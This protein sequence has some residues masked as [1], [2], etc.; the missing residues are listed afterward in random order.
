VGA[1]IGRE[2]SYELLAAVASLPEGELRGALAQLS[3]SELVFCR[4]TPPEATYSFKHALVRDVTHESLLKGRRQQLHARI[5]SALEERF[6][7][8]A[9]V[10]PELL[11]FHYTEALLPEQAA[12]WWMQ[13][14][15]LAGHRS[16]HVEA[17]AHF[18][19]SLDLLRTLPETPERAKRELA[20]LLALGVSLQ[21]VRGPGSDEV[22]E[23]YTQA[24][25][26]C[27]EGSA[28]FE[29]FAAVWGLWR[30]QNHRQHLED[31][32]RLA[33][34]LLGLAER[35]SD[36]SFRLQAYHA[37]WSTAQFGDD[38]ETVLGFLRAGLALYDE[39]L[40]RTPLYLL[41]GHDPAVCGHGSW[42][43]VSW[44]LGHPEQAV[45]AIDACLG[46]A[47]ELQQASSLAHGLRCAVEFYLLCVD[48]DRLHALA[49]E[50]GA[51]AAEQG[52]AGHLATATFGR[53]WAL[54]LQG[55]A[56]EGSAQMSRGAA[57]RRASGT[58]YRENLYQAL[59]REAYRRA[60][61]RGALKALHGESADADASGVAVRTDTV[62]IEIVR[63][64]GELLLFLDPARQAAAQGCFEQAVAAAR[65][66]GA[67]LLEL[68][69]A[70]SLARLLVERG[71]R[72]KA[73]D[74]LAS[75]YGWFTEGLDTP[76][77]KEAEA[78]VE[79]LASTSLGS[80]VTPGRH[81]AIPSE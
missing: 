54:V 15:L 59:L 46:L 23:V 39:R 6:P 41:S 73:H 70:R 42:A 79:K 34:E 29:E 12:A 66:R 35:Q 43:E 55:R 75:V 52:F 49:D 20:V 17:T 78:L 40:R 36:P 19:K 25:R 24:R 28:A 72:Q 16:A 18:R 3:R 13:A 77:L 27:R 76:D 63:L 74:L 61:L 1:A 9:E 50:L 22:D 69:A 53:G 11:A 26:L 71:E 64:H 21:D 58:T 32:Y 4:G 60:G 8:M 62:E 47:R 51:L 2:F 44:L 31:A 80:R 14:G 68:R 7:E 57:S 33:G 37:L 56:E 48:P 65:R 45:A 5:A 10:Q 67:K 38:P 30:V 81:S